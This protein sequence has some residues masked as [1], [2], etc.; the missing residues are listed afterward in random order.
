MIN[1]YAD[2]PDTLTAHKLP[3]SRGRSNEVQWSLKQALVAIE[4]LGD[5]SDQEMVQDLA[6]L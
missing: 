1:Y 4:K 6:N 5:D 2:R 3:K